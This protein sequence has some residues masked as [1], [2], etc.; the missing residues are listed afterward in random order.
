MNNN[1]IEVLVSANWS[2]TNWDLSWQSVIEISELLPKVGESYEIT[3]Q[4]SEA[5]YTQNGIHSLLWLPPHSELNG[6]DDRPTEVLKAHVVE[7]ELLEDEWIQNGMMLG[8]ERKYIAKIIG[9]Q[10]LI[11]NLSQLKITKDTNFK[12]YFN[13]LERSTIHYYVWD[14]YLYLTHS[15]E[16]VKEEFLFKES[17]QGYLLIFINSWVSYS[18][19]SEICKVELNQ[20][21]NKFIQ[22]LLKPWNKLTPNIQIFVD[23][24][25]VQGALYY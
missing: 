18:Y 25:Q 21:Q 2:K 22:S 10:K 17:E 23:E 3:L 14:H 4:D 15:A 5:D 12:D 11:E 7:A 16:Y 9:V 1:K 8:R 19:K 24:G 13:H 20:Q 6:L